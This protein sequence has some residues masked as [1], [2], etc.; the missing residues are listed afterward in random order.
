MERSPTRTAADRQ[1]ASAIRRSAPPPRPQERRRTFQRNVPAMGETSEQTLDDD[2]VAPGAA[3]LAVTLVDTDLAEARL[4]QERPAR[5]VLHEH[6][7]DELPESGIP[8]LL[9]QPFH[10]EPAGAG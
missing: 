1:D 8:R 10:G 2:G 4:L 5:R 7:R 3:Q 9:H 6:A